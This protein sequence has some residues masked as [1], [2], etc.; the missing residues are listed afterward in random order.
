MLDNTW[1]MLDKTFKLLDN[2]ITYLTRVA[3]INIVT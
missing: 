3:T 2:N 1:K